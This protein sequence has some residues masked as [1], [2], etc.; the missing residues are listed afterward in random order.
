MGGDVVG[1]LHQ[2]LHVF[3]CLCAPRALSS[4]CTPCSPSR[5]RKILCV[6]CSDRRKATCL[7]LAGFLT[8]PTPRSCDL[9]WRIAGAQ[10][11]ASASLRS[12]AHRSAG[13]PNTLDI[14]SLL[15]P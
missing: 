13:T 9:V 2:F 1:T 14:S 7:S 10:S 12:R 6:R 4:G 15:F 8:S 11:L 5:R 3:L